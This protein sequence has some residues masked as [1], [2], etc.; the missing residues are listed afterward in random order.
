M[1]AEPDDETHAT[2][3][4]GK[5]KVAETRVGCALLWA[6]VL[7]RLGDRYHVWSEEEVAVHSSR[8]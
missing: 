3:T 2:T 8:S 5:E 6:G 1:E 4:P 7:D